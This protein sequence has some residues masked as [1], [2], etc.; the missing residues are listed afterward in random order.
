MASIK[1][2]PIQP[3]IAKENRMV[4]CLNSII[5][6]PTITK[7][8]TPNSNPLKNPT[9]ISFPISLSFFWNVKFSSINTRM[10]TA[11]DCVPTFPDISKIKD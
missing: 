1:D 7:D 6:S 5:Y 4:L 3:E 10:V 11:R 8:R 9:R 2:T